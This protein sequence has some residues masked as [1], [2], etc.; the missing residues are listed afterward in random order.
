MNPTGSYLR[1][2]QSRDWADACQAQS[3]FQFV[4]DAPL[5]LMECCE[6]KDHDGH[7]H[8]VTPDG[9]VDVRWPI[10]GGER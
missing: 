5:V 2:E 3:W 6:D 1:G 4:R 8:A 7:H 10:F 9:F